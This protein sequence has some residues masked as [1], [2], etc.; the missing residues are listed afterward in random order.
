MGMLVLAFG[1]DARSH[2]G[3]VVKD[4]TSRCGT[5]EGMR[6]EVL[7]A[8]SFGAGAPAARTC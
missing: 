8:A 2:R 4:T 3:D 1:I 5:R 7:T 6:A